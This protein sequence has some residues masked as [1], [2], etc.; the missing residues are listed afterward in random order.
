MNKLNKEEKIRIV[1]ELKEK[2]EKA[3]GVVFTDYRGL[4]VEEMTEMRNSLRSAGLE[5]KVVKNTLAKLA[6]ADTDIEAVKDIFNGPI[7]IAAGY[8]DPVLL[9]KKVL[10]YSKANDK[11]EI[12]GGVVEGGVCSPEQIKAISG[13]PPREVL[14]SMLAAGM[15]APATKMAG[16][17]NATLA[18]FVYALEALKDKKNNN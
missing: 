7:G 18:Q 3:R 10:E 14:L 16:L 4:N 6:A 13:L 17:L 9:L 12:K 1:S 11:L 2:F 8:D 15:Q 5:Y